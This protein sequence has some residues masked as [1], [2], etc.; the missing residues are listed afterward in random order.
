L[1]KDD[2]LYELSQSGVYSSEFE[3]VCRDLRREQGFTD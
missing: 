3:K 1:M 2:V